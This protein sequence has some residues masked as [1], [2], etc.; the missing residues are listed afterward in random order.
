[1]YPFINNT[2]QA[3]FA[4]SDQIFDKYDERFARSDEIFYKN[5]NKR[6]R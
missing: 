2:I 3:M 4:Q 6:R 1:M 5:M